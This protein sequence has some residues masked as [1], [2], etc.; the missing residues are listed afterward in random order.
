MVRRVAGVVF[1]AAVRF[2]A[3]FLG[4]AD[5]VALS[6]IFAAV[7]LAGVARLRGAAGFLGEA[8]AAGA[9]S[10]DGVCVGS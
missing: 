5:L 8:E 1:F 2:G 3:A 7:F 9:D 4:G 10:A 6:V